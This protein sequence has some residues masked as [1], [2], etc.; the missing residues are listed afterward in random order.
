MTDSAVMAGPSRQTDQI[1]DAASS[2][3]ATESDR[4]LND[5]KPY[6]ALVA[7]VLV[8]P[9][10]GSSDPIVLRAID[11]SVGGMG[12]VSRQML[13]P[14]TRGAVQ[15]VRSN[16]QRALVGFETRHSR[17]T[18]SLRHET[19]L[20]FTA[21]PEGLS[22]EDFMDEKGRLVTLDPLLDQNLEPGG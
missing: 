15:L 1:I 5:R 3:E 18:G 10:G 20:E 13:H 14:G 8:Q 6:E 2:G 7:V 11:I 22:A 4:R 16:G 21:L 9:E 12:V 19:G 17:Y